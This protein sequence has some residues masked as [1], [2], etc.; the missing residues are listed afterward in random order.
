MG[1]E[2]YVYIMTGSCG[3]FYVG[4]ANNLFR[5]VSEHKG[6][7]CKFTARYRLTRL[8]YFEST[9]DIW[10]A[11]ERE[12]QIKRWRR[13]KKIRLIKKMNPRFLDLSDAW[14]IRATKVLAESRA[15]S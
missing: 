12:K 13:E 1:R 10:C 11:L 6:G 14:Q 5:R 8:V 15:S 3:T 2:Y 4:V 7:L 9:N